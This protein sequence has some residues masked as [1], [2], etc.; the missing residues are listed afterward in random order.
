MSCYSRSVRRAL[1]F[2]LALTACAGGQRWRKTGELHRD[3]R[4]VVQTEAGREA[5]YAHPLELDEQALAQ[6]LCELRYI[7]RWNATRKDQEQVPWACED[8]QKVAAAIVAGLHDAGPNERV[9]FWVH[10]RERDN[11]APWYVPDERHTR[12]IAY[13]NAAGQLQL[14][15]DLVDRVVG[16]GGRATRAPDEGK[17]RRVRF[18]PPAGMDLAEH[19]GKRQPMRLIWPIDDGGGRDTLKSDVDPALRARLELLEE[20]HRAGDIDEATYERRNA[21]LGASK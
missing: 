7:D 21:E 8:A 16:E 2:G 17:N 5:D 6:R 3:D 20:M 13:R 11:A 12:G 4:V 9:R 10:W 18:I 1:I 15:F 14:D 19:D